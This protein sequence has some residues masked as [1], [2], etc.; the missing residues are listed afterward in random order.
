MI[1]TPDKGSIFMLWETKLTDLNNLKVIKNMRDLKRAAHSQG[2]DAE[3]RDDKTYGSHG[4][5]E[6][7]HRKT[8]EK[9]KSIPKSCSCSP[10]LSPIFFTIS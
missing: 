7:T 8:G 2:Y 4:E 1:N 9:L 6:I 3:D 10:I 5:V